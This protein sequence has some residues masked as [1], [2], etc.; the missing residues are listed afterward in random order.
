M[1]VRYLTTESDN[2]GSESGGWSSEILRFSGFLRRPEVPS[3]G[4]ALRVGV[5]FQVPCSSY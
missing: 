4:K 1:V 2:A 5:T 3:I